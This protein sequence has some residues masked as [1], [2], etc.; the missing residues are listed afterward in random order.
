MKSMI[1]GA[2]IGT[3]FLLMVSSCATVPT[4][5]PAPGEV[6]LLGIEFQKF[7]DIRAKF[8]SVVNINFEA[9][10]RPEMTRACFHWASDGPFCYMVTN[11]NYGW[12]TIKVDLPIPPFISSG[13]YT[14][15]SYVLY[16]RDG[17]QLRTN[18]VG[19]Q[20]YVTK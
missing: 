6:K 2:L 18:I 4:E 5:P 16:I 19:T 20:V 10:G 1:L 3:T 8:S 11:V 7:G 17:K 15:K 12:G 14:L 9:D 13:S